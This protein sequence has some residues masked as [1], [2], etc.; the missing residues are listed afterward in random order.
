VKG[1]LEELLTARSRDVAA[2]ISELAAFDADLAQ[3]REDL[4]VP[5][6]A[7][8]CDD[9]CGCTSSQVHTIQRGRPRPIGPAHIEQRPAGPAEIAVACTLSGDG[10]ATRFA[11]WAELFTQAT[12]QTDADGGVEITFPAV[13][14]LAGRLAALPA[15]EKECC[16]FFAFTL[17]ITATASITLHI[18]GPQDAE[19]LVAELLGQIVL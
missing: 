7:G 14:D 9:N 8:P 16:S 18:R 6:P 4:A 10:Q 11:E 1:R 19:P 2:R 17:D 5:S 3:A 15:R 13:P 12:G